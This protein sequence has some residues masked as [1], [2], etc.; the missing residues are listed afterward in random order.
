[1]NTINKSGKAVNFFFF[2]ERLSSSAQS[3]RDLK[4]SLK[5]DRSVSN[6]E[7]LDSFYMKIA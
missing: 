7:Y 1:M 6:T 3:H 2:I 4:E 5:S